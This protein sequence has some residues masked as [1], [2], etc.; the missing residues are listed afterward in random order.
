MS[1]KIYFVATFTVT[2]GVIDAIREL[3]KRPSS[4]VASRR[5]PLTGA[6]GVLD[7]TE[8]WFIHGNH[9]T[10]LRP[11]TTIILALIGGQKSR[12][13]VVEIVVC[14]L[15]LGGGIFQRSSLAAAR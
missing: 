15:R 9:D 7:E 8:I 1:A 14:V 10:V 3:R 6:P 11:T 4:W 12:W 5:K 2:F 13:R